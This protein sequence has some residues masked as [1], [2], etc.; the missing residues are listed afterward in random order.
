MQRIHPKSRLSPVNSCGSLLLFLVLAAT[1]DSRAIAA[2]ALTQLPV[3]IQDD[4]K[5]VCLPVQYQQGALAYRECI[6]NEL[7]AYGN[8]KAG[9]PVTHLSFDDKYAVQQACSNA[10]EKTSATYQNLSLIHI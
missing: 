3:N 8:T 5:T 10:G 6:N 1:V 9:S 4:I 7:N 2:E